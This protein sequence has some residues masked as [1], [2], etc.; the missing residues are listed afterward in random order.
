[1]NMKPARGLNSWRRHHLGPS[2]RVAFTL[3]ELLVVIAI[4]AI[5]VAIL[6]PAIAIVEER[7]HKAKCLS[8]TRQIAQ[9]AMTLFGDLKEGL[10]YL[11]PNP[12]DDWSYFGRAAGQLMPYLKYASEVF[13]CP[14][15]PGFA[16][17]PKYEITNAPGFYTDYEVTGFLCQLGAPANGHVYYRKQSQIFDYSQVAYAYDSPYKPGDPNRPHDGGVNCAY[18]DGHAAWLPDDQMGPLPPLPTDETTFFNK[19]HHIWRLQ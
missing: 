5:L 8:N 18:L 3:I 13:D 11:G 10:P 4:I 7:A 15:N 1:M 9:A 12:D 17:D 6:F 14:A 16:G 2:R 19:G